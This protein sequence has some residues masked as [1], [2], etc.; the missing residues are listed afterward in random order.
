ML[1][2]DQY[3]E[4]LIRHSVEL[5]FAPGSG[6]GQCVREQVEAAAAALEAAGL[7]TSRDVMRWGDAADEALERA[8][9]I[10][11]VN[12]NKT[13]SDSAVMTPAA[14]VV[15]PPPEEPRP[16]FV[17][18][19]P[20]CREFELRGQERLVV[21]SLAQWEHFFELSYAQIDADETRSG[22]RLGPRADRRWEIVD[23]RGMRYQVGGWN[24]GS[25]G[26][27]R[28]SRGA[29]RVFPA[30]GAGATSLHVI[31]LDVDEVV[32]AFEVDLGT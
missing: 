31:L 6:S 19:V 20:I 22:G 9:L 3:L 11:R 24:R 4:N 26:S 14:G 17:R 15:A 32:A 12:I 23:D 8:G 10:S 30:V 16:E 29:I 18:L 2:A 27:R 5:A 1:D 25:S 13:A 21:L 7:Q 28:L